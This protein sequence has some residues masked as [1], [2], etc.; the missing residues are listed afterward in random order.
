MSELTQ[1]ERVLLAGIR[2]GDADAWRQ[3]IDR[4]SGRLLAFAQSRLGDAAEAEDLLQ[5]TFMSFLTVLGDF[6][7]RSSIETYLFTILRRR[8]IDWRRSRRSNICLLADLHHTIGGDDGGEPFGGVSSPDPTASTYARRDERRDMQR[9]A[10]A[11]A[12]K[13]LADD[14][15]NAGDFR[16]L[17]I[18]EMLFYCGLGN[19]EAAVI[20]ELE[21]NRIAVIKHRIIKKARSR[22][23]AD[24]ATDAIEAASESSDRHAYSILTDAWRTHRPSCPKRSTIGA[25]L[26]GT[27]EQ[28]WRKYVDFHLHKL[29][30][31]FCLANMTDINRQ[32]A[33]EPT[34][35]LR[36]R[37]MQST[38]GFLR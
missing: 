33:D 6:R 37:L 4:Y 10:M 25:Y 11:S 5:E 38:V 1:A 23:S 15:S 2:E 36:Q 28:P 26:L 22:I 16:D 30:C 17:M 24:F 31:S 21:E 12:I 19:S 3:L 9:K 7:E 35:P 8:I 32:S 20:A 29:G 13:A 14:C 34:S 27:L 18:A